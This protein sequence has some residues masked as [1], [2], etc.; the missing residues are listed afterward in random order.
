MNVCRF[1]D[2]QAEQGSETERIRETAIDVREEG[3][4]E[5]KCSVFLSQLPVT[6]P[7]RSCPLLSYSLSHIVNTNHVVFRK[8]ARYLAV[9]EYSLLTWEIPRAEHSVV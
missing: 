6:A 1:R 9:S 8:T 4:E 3:E 2:C 7:S 5:R